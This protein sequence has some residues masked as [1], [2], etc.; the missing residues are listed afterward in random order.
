MDNPDIAKYLSVEPVL[1]FDLVKVHGR[2][3][4]DGLDLHDPR[5]S[6]LFGEMKGLPPVTLYTGTRELL[7]PDLLLLN[8][9]LTTAGVLVDLHV[10]KGLNHE[11][12]LM[13]IPEGRR[14]VRDTAALLRALKKA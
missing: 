10:G 3:W 8:D 5:V 2:Y 1:H 9:A 7:Y 11:Y 12:P 4:A 6:P 13:P 14:A